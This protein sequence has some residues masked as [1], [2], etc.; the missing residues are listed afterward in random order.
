[1]MNGGRIFLRAVDPGFHDLEDEH[2]VFVHHARI[3]YLAFEVGVAFGNQRRGDASGGLRSETKF[4]EFVEDT[5]RS[6][7]TADNF[8]CQLDGGNV[9]D[10]FPRFS[11]NVKREIAIADYARNGGGYEI[12]H[13]VPRHGHHVG[14]F[15]A[16]GRDQH[17]WA[18]LQK[19][20]DLR[21]RKRRF[22]HIGKLQRRTRPLAAL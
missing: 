7:S 17:D 2:T 13:H 8:L 5:A 14:S 20:V 12:N 1:M 4:L 15:A 21:Q 6:I 11:Q 22:V 9:D 16:R 18:G 10:A 19:A 3:A